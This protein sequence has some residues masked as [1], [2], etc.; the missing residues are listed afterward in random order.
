M[1]LEEIRGRPKDEKSRILELRK[2]DEA[3]VEMSNQDLI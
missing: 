1:K 2:F 3:G